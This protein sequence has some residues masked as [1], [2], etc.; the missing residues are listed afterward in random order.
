MAVE[1]YNL[2]LKV[3]GT[4]KYVLVYYVLGA[5]GIL[6]DMVNKKYNH[7]GKFSTI[8]YNLFGVNGTGLLWLM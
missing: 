5:K 2:M 3:F 1:V 6:H 4:I 7:V 8:L